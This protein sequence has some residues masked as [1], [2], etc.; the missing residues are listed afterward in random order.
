MENAPKCAY[1]ENIK[2]VSTVCL[3]HT[4]NGDRIKH[5]LKTHYLNPLPA[6]AEN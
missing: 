2:L 3:K 5:P 1:E 6:T 4:D